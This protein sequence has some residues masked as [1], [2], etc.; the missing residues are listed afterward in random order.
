MF[1][2]KGEFCRKDQMIWAH[3]GI[4]FRADVYAV[5]KMIGRLTGL[6]SFGGHEYAAYQ[7]CIYDQPN[8]WYVLGDIGRT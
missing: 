6:V 5:R 2:Y 4:R 1:A 3:G 7:V 8:D